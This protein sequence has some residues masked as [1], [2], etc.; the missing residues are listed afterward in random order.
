MSIKD[1]ESKGNLAV[2]PQGLRPRGRVIEQ[3]EA[4]DLDGGI[5]RL[6]EEMRA[7]RR[8]GLFGIARLK[9]E[10]WLEEKM[11]EPAIRKLKAQQAVLFEQRRTAQAQI[12]LRSTVFTGER[13]G[14]R[15]RSEVNQARAH[16]LQTDLDSLGIGQ[17]DGV[18]RPFPPKSGDPPLS[19]HISD[20]QIE[21]LAL[22]AVSNI[23]AGLAGEEGLKAYFSELHDRLPK[24]VA[25]EVETRIRALRRT[26][27]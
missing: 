7:A 24:Y 8:S 3:H 17:D 22:K 2:L 27:S 11:K 25:D 23:P 5:G 9:W 15:G 16:R 20:Q 10:A 18:P 1:S 26:M 13:D 14:E 12:D 21:A 19:V 6:E 4:F